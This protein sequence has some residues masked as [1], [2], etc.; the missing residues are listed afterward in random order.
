M[1]QTENI[2]SLLDAPLLRHPQADS[3]Q[4]Q[5]YLRLRT[6]ILQQQFPAG[7]RLPG[8]RGLAETLAISRNTVLSVYEQLTAEGFLLADKR[9][10]I[11]ANVSPPSSPPTA[12]SALRYS[13]R[14]AAMR[15]DTRMPS[16]EQLFR[17][18]IPALAQFPI[19]AWQKSLEH[20]VSAHA[21]T[22]LNYGDPL[23]V[24][25]LRQ[26]IAQH[27]AIS[28]GM[29]CKPEQVVIT[30]GAQAALNLCVQ[31]FSNSGEIGWM[32]NPGYQGA[33][34]A[35]RC[36]E[37]QLHPM[38][39]DA[40]GIVVNAADWE[41]HP[42]ALIYTTPS[43]QY[44][45]GSVLSV[46]RRL[47]LIHQAKAHQAWIIEDDYDS[48]YRHSGVP[49]VAMQG[50]VDDAP[51][52]YVGSFSKT[53]FPALRL[54]F[55]VLPERVM[56]QWHVDIANIVRGGHLHSQLALSWWMQS[57]QYSRH[58]A[59]MR[60]LYRDRQAALKVA[61]SEHLQIPHD[62]LGG[63]AGLHLTV[64]LPAIYPDHQITQAAKAYGMAVGALSAFACNGCEPQ[65]GL[66]LGYG[67]TSV[68]QYA[69]LLQRLTTIVM[70]IKK[71][72][73]R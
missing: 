6:A 21:P 44:P 59:R 73:D 67:N 26:E 71:P 72:H 15:G 43:H 17:V 10:T 7:C 49:V 28:R 13:R 32:E 18:G 42:P 56:T 2:H 61:L 20:A 4:W 51:V 24:W 60:K 40:A 25:S 27:L 62:I 31:L 70:A 69:G 68:D 19:K 65:N 55:L 45:T 1:T 41:T 8:S 57:G 54:G 34:T 63:A 53:L 12:T 50:L 33:R 3:L 16:K 46:Q 29:R 9:G 38:P 58:L 22:A 47:A 48:E 5:L 36:G 14:L 52:L 66:V 37:L 11:V 39:V 64:R 30:E 23:G 35:M